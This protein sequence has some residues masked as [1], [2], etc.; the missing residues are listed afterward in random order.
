MWSAEATR[1]ALEGLHARV[2]LATGESLVADCVALADGSKSSADSMM[3]EFKSLERGSGQ[4]AVIAKVRAAQPKLHVAY[5]RFTAGGA[6]ALIPRAADA[7]VP[8]WTLVWA[9][10]DTEAGRMLALDDASFNDEINSAFGT[11]MGELSVVSKRSSYPLVWRFVEPRVRGPVVAVGNAAQAL[12]PVAAQGLNLGLRDAQDLAR[13]L[14]NSNHHGNESESIAAALANFARNRALDRVTTV[15]FSGL[16]AY[17]FDR[18]GW[19]LDVPRGLGLMA[20]QMLPPAKRELLRRMA[21]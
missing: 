21:L 5:E 9:R 15:G 8:E 17:G 6:L 16:L 12:H 13:A 20:L 10:G 4:T 11:P 2:S 1:V 3:P 14:Q 7:G 18:G 19:L